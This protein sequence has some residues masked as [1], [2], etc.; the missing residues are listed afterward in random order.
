ME[1]MRSSGLP[2]DSTVYQVEDL[3]SAQHGIIR[4]KGADV[5]CPRDGKQGAAYVD[6]LQGAKNVGPANVMLSYCWSYTV[7]DIV[8]TLEEYCEA[9]E[10]DP[11]ET[12]AWICC[13]CN[14]QHRV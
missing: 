8:K 6:C 7:L 10:L 3:D 14:N 11:K 1:E 12:Y 13:L 9:K 2:E 4:Q 5:V